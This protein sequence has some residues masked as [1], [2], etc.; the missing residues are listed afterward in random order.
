M[1]SQRMI[2]G[3]QGPT[4][5][6]NTAFTS[7]RSQPSEE[8]DLES[9][10]EVSE[11]PDDEEMADVGE[12]GEDDEDENEN[13][14]NDDEDNGYDGD[15]DDEN[16]DDSDEDIMDIRE[17]M[18]DIDIDPDETMGE[19]EMGFDDVAIDE[20]GGEEEEEEESDSDSDA[21]LEAF[22]G[23]EAPSDRWH[24]VYHVSKGLFPFNLSLT[25]DEVSWCRQMM[26]ER[27]VDS[28][29]GKGLKSY[30]KRGQSEMARFIYE[31]AKMC[32][33]SGFDTDFPPEVY[34][35]KETFWNSK[36]EWLSYRLSFAAQIEAFAQN[37]DLQQVIGCDSPSRELPLTAGE[38]LA[39]LF[40]RHEQDDSM[41]TGAAYEIRLGLHVLVA[42]VVFENFPLPM[43]DGG[44]VLKSLQ[45][46]RRDSQRSGGTG[47]GP[48]GIA[49]GINLDDDDVVVFGPVDRV[50]SHGDKRLNLT[51]QPP[52]LQN[53]RIVKKSYPIPIRIQKR[54]PRLTIFLVR[55]GLGCRIDRLRAKRKDRKRHGTRKQWSCE[56]TVKCAGT[57]FKSWKKRAHRKSKK[58]AVKSVG[59]GLLHDLNTD[60]NAYHL[61]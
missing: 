44:L 28:E 11:T 61:Q 48:W 37:F 6:P 49:E 5:G 52:A 15:D 1:R 19:L 29:K 8:S 2:F 45:D 54:C 16:D 18:C 31:T 33:K 24:P 32:A 23:L 41:G 43:V 58:D 55:N 46:V 39:L 42:V 36:I 53:M 51:V 12:Y 17:G 26:T 57:G 4:E 10:A 3:S 56:V 40:S 38:V 20:E 35:K 14:E 30:V 59:L 13:D 22:S 47:F 25:E 34:K 21:D 60:Y 7:H 27:P 50:D 9:E